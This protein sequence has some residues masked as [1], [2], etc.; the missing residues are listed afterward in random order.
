VAKPK[1]PHDAFVK[2][3][4]S[5][6]ENA[7]AMLRSALPQG[8]SQRIDWQSLRLESGSHVDHLLSDTHTDL[9]FST[10]I[11]GRKALFY[12]LFE[13]QST[14]DALMPFRLLKY[15]VRVLDW[16]LE[17][18]KAIG[19]PELP[20][21][22]VVP[23]VLHHSERGWKAPTEVAALF[24]PFLADDPELSRLLPR[25][26]FVLDDISHLSDEELGERALGAAVALALW[27]LRDSRQ[28][29]RLFASLPHFAHLIAN[30]LDAP[31]GRDAVLVLFRYLSLVTE[32]PPSTFF[33]QVQLHAPETKETLM[34]VAEQLEAKGRAEGEAKG[35]AEGE[36]K[37]RAEGEAKAKAGAIL[38]VLEA[39]QKVVTAEQRA[40]VEGC[41]DL[42]VL[43]RCLRK[44]A[45]LNDT[46]ELFEQ[47]E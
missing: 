30:L 3:T 29:E 11:A 7:A 10:S 8:L 45:T 35:R 5:N 39:R 38:A 36:A 41:S 24:D 47:P 18:A 15:I 6:L 26:S 1:G 16:H 23:V 31:S 12:V 19:H 28:P 27:A 44:A 34:T 42:A 9:L 43:D 46:G 4:F 17:N 25:L 21:P 20:L 32:V 14:S 33:E 13:H 40:K 37:G 22:V 2:Y